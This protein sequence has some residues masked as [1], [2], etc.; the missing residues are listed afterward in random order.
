MKIHIV[1][2]VHNRLAETKKCVASINSQTYKNIQ[3]Y[4]VDDGSTDGTKAWVE[5]IDA[6]LIS[7]SGN[8]WWT[9]AVA[10]AFNLIVPNV[11]GN[12]FFMVLSNDA[13]LDENALDLLVKASVDRGYAVCGS[14][15]VDK[16]TN[17]CMSSG[18]LVKSWILNIN[19]HPF[20]YEKLIQIS[21][22]VE[23]VTMLTGRSLIFPIKILKKSGNFDSKSLPHYGGDVEM[24]I[25]LGNLGYSLYI[26][27]TSIIYVN[28][29][30]TGL[31]PGDRKMTVFDRALSLF[32]IKSAN[33]I[34][35]R[36]I[37][38]LK[39]APIYALPSYLMV[40]YM[41]IIFSLFILKRKE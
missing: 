32:S 26:V 2:A 33:S 37:L 35:Y 34:Y 5:S 7:G 30:E 16:K 15:S 38:A 40:T 1:I 12:D 21:K 22:K 11:D 39:I 31:N 24:T 29:E 6:T 18:A 13:V 20:R 28:R 36:T 8:L 19:Y 14:L 23:L 3:L 27:P 9:G 41:K 25:R 10:A 4:I 17:I